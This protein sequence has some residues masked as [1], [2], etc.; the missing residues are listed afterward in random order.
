MHVM[1]VV[2]SKSTQMPGGLSCFLVFLQELLHALGQASEYSRTSRSA[3]TVIQAENR[4]SWLVAH[5][6][7]MLRYS[8]PCSCSSQAA[9]S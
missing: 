6:Y 9:V 2:P 7:N 8:A 3:V 4:C 1:L 5:F